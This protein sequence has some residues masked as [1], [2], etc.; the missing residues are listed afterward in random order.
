MGDGQC[1]WPRVSLR[2]ILTNRPRERSWSLAE[3]RRVKHLGIEQRATKRV[4]RG[5]LRRNGCMDILCVD[6][7]L[8]FCEITI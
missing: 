3:A 6:L 7:F 5:C 2:Q 1:E 4:C 8:P